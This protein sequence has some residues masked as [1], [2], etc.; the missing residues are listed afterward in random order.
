MSVFRRALLRLSFILLSA[1]AGLAVVAAAPTGPLPKAE[2]FARHPAIDDV[3]V[4]PSGKR[5]AVLLFGATGWRQLAVIDL[6]PL[7]APRVVASYNNANVTRALWVDDDRLVYDAFP[8]EAEVRSGGAGTF[9]VD[10]DGS[11][12]RQLI[13]WSY[14]TGEGSRMISR[15]LPYGWFLHSAIDDGSGDV[16]VVRRFAEAS[17]DLRAV[18]LSRMNSRTGQVK[19]LSQGAPDDAKGWIVDAT[20]QPRMVTGWSDGRQRLYWRASPNSEWQKVSD[21]DYM[22]DNDLA[23]WNVAPD[24][25]VLMKTTLS[26]FNALHRFDPVARKLDPEPLVAVKGFDLDATPVTD[27]RTGNLLGLHFIADRP[28]SVWFDDTLNKLQKGIDAALPTGRFNRLYCGRCESTRFFVVRSASDRHPGEFLLFDRK[29]ASIERIGDARPWIDEATQGRRSFHRF[30]ARDGLM[31]PVVVTHPAGA[32]DK[33]A[34]PTVMMVHGGPWVR[35]SDL[36]WEADAQFYASRGWRVLQPEF[37]G[38]DGFGNA[39]LRAGWKQWGRAMQDDLVDTVN[40]AAKQGWV[41]PSRVCIVGASYG[42]YAALMGPI[43]HPDAWRCAASFAGVTDINLMF[44]SHWSDISE[45][46]KRHSM[47]VMIGDPKT[48][49]AALAA[50]SPLRRASEIKVPVLLAHG[51]IDRRVTLN[52]AQDFLKAARAGGV[53]IEW[54]FYPDEGHGFYLEANAADHYRRLEAFLGKVLNAP[55]P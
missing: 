20:G 39:H 45:E 31:V 55:K 2:D 9:A 10:H 27:T 12:Q 48:E 29:K 22:A 11:N 1:S 17:G 53:D 50:V 24:G 5:L 52:H 51:G 34:L 28:M 35:G 36:T 15:V 47:P 42:G 18:T 30:A 44:D 8:R 25:Q 4:S 37:R 14:A 54:V 40:W 23:P 38:S 49:A 19:G 7:G 6:D 21:L 32:A 16:L 41:D 43:A 46:G 3:V 13:S 26:G 33:Q